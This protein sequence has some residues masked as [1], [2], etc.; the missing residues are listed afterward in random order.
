MAVERAVASLRRDADRRADRVHHA[1]LL[2]ARS[3][4]PHIGKCEVLR[5]GALRLRKGARSPPEVRHRRLE[6]ER[7]DVVGGARRCPSSASA[8]AISARRVRAHDVHVVDVARLVL[9]AARRPRPGRA[10]RSA[11]QPR[12]ARRSSRR[13]AAGR[14]AASLPGWRRAASSSRSARRSACRATRG[15]GAC[16]REPATSS[17][18]HATRPPSPSAKRF[19]VGKKLNVE[20]TPTCA[21][22]SAPN[23]CAASSTIG[24]P[25][26]ASSATGAGRPKRCTGDDR[27]RPRRDPRG[28]VLR[29]EVERDR[30]DVGEDRRRADP[31]D[32]LGGRVERERRA[33]HLVA[34]TDSHCLEREDERVRA[35]RD[36]DRVRDAEVGGR[37]ALERLDLGPEDEAAGL[38]DGREALL[39]LGDQRRVLRLHV[40]EWDLLGHARECSSAARFPQ[41]AEDSSARRRG[42]VGT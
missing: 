33:D 37:L 28:D 41:P 17:S 39:E 18:R 6:M 10:P 30:V 29:V 9:R 35:V 1:L 23:A 25:S 32:R 8:A 2:L 16:A 42:G 31:G 11:R 19:F 26:A 34:A 36:A 14:R 38:E 27:L 22:P 12:A 24:R 3:I 15:S 4:P 7:G 5:G 21:T 20:Q 40:D 13:A